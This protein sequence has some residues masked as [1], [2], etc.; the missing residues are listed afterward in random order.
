MRCIGPIFEVRRFTV[1]RRISKMACHLSIGMNRLK[2][3]FVSL[4]KEE[5]F[6]HF[7]SKFGPK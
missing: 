4:E 5:E 6:R 1:A 7:E 3:H 2:T